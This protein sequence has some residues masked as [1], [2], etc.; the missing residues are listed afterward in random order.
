[1]SS[2]W[3]YDNHCLPWRL[4]FFLDRFILQYFCCVLC[5]PPTLLVSRDCRETS[6]GIVPVSSHISVETR[7]QLGLLVPSVVW[8][9]F[10][11]FFYI[12]SVYTWAYAS[13]RTRGQSA[14]DSEKLYLGNVLLQQCTS[15]HLT[16]KQRCIIPLILANT[17]SA[18][19]V[20]Q[21]QAGKVNYPSPTS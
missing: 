9:C 19:F 20:Q 15:L 13:K 5:T 12:R 16:P 3:L 6:Q 8:S 1:M 11:F 4:S 18:L 21:Y 10:F 7:I 14:S 17:E 2:L